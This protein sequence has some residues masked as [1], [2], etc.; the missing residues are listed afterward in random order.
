MTA[1]SKYPIVLKPLPEDEG[2]GWLALVPDLPGCMSDGALPAEALANVLDAIEEWKDAAVELGRAI[3][4]PD[5]ALAAS[6][7]GRLSEAAE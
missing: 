6:L 3:P 1:K 5:P 7:G 4:E 2:G